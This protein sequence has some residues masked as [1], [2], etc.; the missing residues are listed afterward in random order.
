MGDLIAEEVAKQLGKP[1]KKYPEPPLKQKNK[2]QE[3]KNEYQKHRRIENPTLT[4]TNDKKIK[5]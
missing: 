5:L 4:P 3:P 1:L 2:Y